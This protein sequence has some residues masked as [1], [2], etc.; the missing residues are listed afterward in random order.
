[1]I[2]WKANGPILASV[3]ELVAA[4]LN[5]ELATTPHLRMRMAASNLVARL[6]LGMQLSCATCIHVPV[7]IVGGNEGMRMRGG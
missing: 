7:F 3:L 1:M 4:G 6:A 2:P 5:P